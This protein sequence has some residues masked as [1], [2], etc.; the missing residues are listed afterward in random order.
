MRDE[1]A[2]TAAKVCETEAAS[3][4]KNV[5]MSLDSDFASVAPSTPLAALFQPQLPDVQHVPAGPPPA[6]SIVTVF[7]RLRL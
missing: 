1:G 7:G 2:A 3:V 6:L 4:T 5:G